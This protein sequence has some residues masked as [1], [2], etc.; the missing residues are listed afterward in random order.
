MNFMALFFRVSNIVPMA[1]CIPQNDLLTAPLSPVFD[2]L[3]GG[4][5]AFVVKILIVAVLLFIM[6]AAI[7][8]IARQKSA[9][10]DLSALVWIA[11]VIPAV[12]LALVII[13]TLFGA[14]NN[15]C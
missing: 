6:I 2:L 9:K 8:K 11:A 7:I 5:G 15:I 14:M 1:E 4:L 3:A 12:I 10:E 13:K